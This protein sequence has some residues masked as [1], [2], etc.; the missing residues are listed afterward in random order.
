VLFLN[1]WN[2]SLNA[3]VRRKRYQ[4]NF[5]LAS[6]NIRTRR[7]ENIDCIYESFKDASKVRWKCE[8]CSEKFRTFKELMGH[9]VDSHS[10]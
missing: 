8:K 10:Y 6:Y 5:N 7:Y 2:V 1:E 9:K 3:M 4:L